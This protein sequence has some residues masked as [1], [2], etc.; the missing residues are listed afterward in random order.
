MGARLLTLLMLR[1]SRRK[2]NAL[3]RAEETS[4]AKNARRL[5][6]RGAEMGNVLSIGTAADRVRMELL[7]LRGRLAA[8]LAALVP[9]TTLGMLRGVVAAQAGIRRDRGLGLDGEHARLRGM[10]ATTVKTDVT[11]IERIIP[12][13]LE[14]AGEEMAAHVLTPHR[15]STGPTTAQC[16]Q[17]QSVNLATCTTGAG[18]GR[19]DEQGDQGRARGRC[20]STRVLVCTHRMTSRLRLSSHDDHPF[21]PSSKGSFLQGCFP[22]SARSPYLK[23]HGSEQ[24][25]LVLWYLFIQML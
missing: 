5:L 23:A 6:R 21:N 17:M 16:R 15:A 11:G 9:V 20:Q 14:V 24:D 13:W 22:Y 4:L 1:E 18:R 19:R 3:R 8:A 2:R 25:A 10:M 12:T 7:G